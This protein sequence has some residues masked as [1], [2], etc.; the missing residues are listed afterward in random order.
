MK[1][2][3]PFIHGRGKTGQAK[4]GPD[5]VLIKDTNNYPNAFGDFCRIC[6][7]LQKAMDKNQVKVAGSNPN[8]VKSM[9][10]DYLNKLD[11]HVHDTKIAG[12]DEEVIF[13]NLDK[14]TGRDYMHMISVK[15]EGQEIYLR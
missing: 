11:S 10:L 3:I 15:V 6:D 13:L 1:T 8:E 5:R 4:T 7:K 9:L 14:F 2:V 12:I